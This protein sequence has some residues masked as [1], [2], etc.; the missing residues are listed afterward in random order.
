VTEE[1]RG[2]F[3]EKG[4]E[5]MNNGITAIAVHP[6]KSSFVLLGYQ[7][8]QLVLLDLED[9]KKSLKVIKDH[10][11]GVAIMNLAFCESE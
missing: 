6:V 11:K 8:G 3:L 9:P 2:Y 1:P 4:K 7:H 10:H 5:F